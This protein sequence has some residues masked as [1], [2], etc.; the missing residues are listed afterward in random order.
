[1]LLG[2]ADRQ[3]GPVVGCRVIANLHPVHLGDTHR[4]HLGCLQRGAILTAASIVRQVPFGTIRVGRSCST[5]DCVARA[6]VPGRE[7]EHRRRC[8]ANLHPMIATKL[9]DNPCWLSFRAN[10]IAHHFNQPLYDWIAKALRPRARPSTSCSTPSAS[11][12]G[13]TAEDVAASSARPKNTLS[14]A[15]NALVARRLLTR[16]QDT[17]RSPPHA[18]L[19]DA[20]G[21]ADRR[22]DRAGTGRAR[23]GDA[24]ALRSP[25]SARCT[26]C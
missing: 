7:R 14:R 10:F 21:T 15:V 19:P 16:L 1:M 3:D 17:V 23:S 8:R 13:I 6:Y 5:S 4:R 26:S 12:K 9:W 20:A 18:S 24:G 2:G 22:R 25:S 11:R